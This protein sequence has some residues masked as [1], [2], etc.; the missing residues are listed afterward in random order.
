M[1]SSHHHHHHSSGLVPRGSHMGLLVL[2]WSN[3]KKLIEEA[4]KMAEKANLY[5]LTLETDDKKIE[6]IL[7]S[8]GPPVKILVL[9]EDTKDADKVKKEI[10]KKARKKNLPVRIRKV[11]SPDEAKRWIKEFSEE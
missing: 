2:I 4:R 5:L 7:K 1:G 3:D 11:T 9:L 8:L 6:D 10:E